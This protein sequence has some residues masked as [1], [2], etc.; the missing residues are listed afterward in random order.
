MEPEEHDSSDGDGADH[1]GDDEAD[2]V[3]DSGDTEDHADESD[4]SHSAAAADAGDDGHSEGVIAAAHG[5]K[6]LIDL[7]ITRHLL[8]AW[9]VMFLLYFVFVGAARKYKAGVGR[10]T[11]PQGRTQN[12]LE[13]LVLFVRDE[14][15]RPNIGEKAGKFVP[16]LL[17][18]FFFILACNLIGLL[19]F[20]TTATS[21]IT[22][23][24]ILAGITFLITQVSG[25]KDYWKHLAGPPGVP[26]F[27]RPLLIPVEIL[28]LFT[29]PF[30]LAIRLFANMTAGH[31]VILSLIGLIF[32][33]T[34]AYGRPVG[35]GTSIVW[36]GFTLFILCLELLVAFL[37]AY[38][39]TMLSALFIGMAVEEHDHEHEHEEAHA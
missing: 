22:V 19:P 1:A 23:T 35:W 34:N 18:V 21:N 7:S 15:A 10:E 36:V 6:I 17:T 2:H 9:I 13:V 11:A 39:F 31:I 27:V 30:A 16:Y 25:T 37:Q 24:A 4:D 28:G 32:T 26:L 14:I 3:D 20:S 8:I 29:K 38:I 12:M 33:F 5:D